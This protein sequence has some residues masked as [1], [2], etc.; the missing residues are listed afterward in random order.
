MKVVIAGAGN[1]GLFIANDLR[2]NG[3]EVRIIEQNQVVVDRSDA[4]LGVEWHVADACEVNSLRRAKLEECE[5][6]VA[7]TG[8]DEDNL[9]FS[10]LA[11]QE[12]AVP[13]V[14]ARVNHPKNEW[15][16]NENWGVDLSVSTPHLVTALVEE[17]V[18]VGRLVRL[19]S[20]EGGNARLVEV[21]LA[22]D[23]PVIDHAIID[24]EIPRDV[25]FVAVVRGQHVVMPRGDTRFQAGDEVLAMVT[26][27]S[28]DDVR[29]I[30]TGA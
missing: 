24:L 12:F 25:T 27:E 8:D 22:D 2:A 26:P 21:T 14:I 1:V 6:A 4:V 11:K 3:H 16:F 5:V 28:E 18:S 15:L 13:R 7:A 19:L 17:A 9:V 10:L 30:L 20:F 23:S 29:R